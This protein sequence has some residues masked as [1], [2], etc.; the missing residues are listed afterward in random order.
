MSKNTNM[1]KGVETFG[2]YWEILSAEK[3]KLFFRNSLGFWVI[4][5]N[6]EF[7]IYALLERTKFYV[8]DSI[9]FLTHCLLTLS[10]CLCTGL[11]H[12]CEKQQIE[13]ESGNTVTEIVLAM[14]LVWFGSF[15][16]V[17][18]LR[19]FGELDLNETTFRCH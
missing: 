12:I 3:Y 17:I 7:L 2:E 5:H 11:N 9:P 14:R 16:V 8:M 18:L 19:G 1:R 13:V 10:I 6:P 4:Q 15:I